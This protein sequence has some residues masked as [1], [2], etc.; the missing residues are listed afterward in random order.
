[1]SI[2]DGGL[3][4]DDRGTIRYFNC[5]DPSAEDIKRMYLIENHRL[6]TC[7]AWHGHMRE[8]K[9][10]TVTKGAALIAVVSITDDPV[11]TKQTPARHVLS[12]ANPQ[13]LC[14]S[15]GVANGTMNLTD[16]CQILVF[17]NFTLE[18]SKNDDYRFP[19]NTWDVNIWRIKAR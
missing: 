11:D 8:A 1:M 3:S 4:T 19:W 14:L 9:Y 2:I 16:D 13:I 6:G 7:R 12:A 15:P 18:E 17:S 5:F 10:M